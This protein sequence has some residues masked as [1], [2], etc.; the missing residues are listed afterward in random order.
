MLLPLTRLWINKTRKLLLRRREMPRRQLR[1]R[2]RTKNS[3][4]KKLRLMPR[5]KRRLKRRLLRRRRRL[6][7]RL[8]RRLR[9]KIRLSCSKGSKPRLLRRRRSTLN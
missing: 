6:L 2:R 9:R 8:E 1:G 4:K 5:P 7:L 3:P